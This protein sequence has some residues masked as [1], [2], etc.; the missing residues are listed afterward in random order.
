MMMM[1]RWLLVVLASSMVALPGS[2]LAQED[3]EPAE[4]TEESADDVAIESD[5]DLDKDDAEAGADIED[6]EGMEAEDPNKIFK[7]DMSAPAGASPEFAKELTQFQSAFERYAR[8][9]TD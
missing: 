7:Q 9:I 2:V 8:E 5:T 6:S 3:D 1:K 4:Q